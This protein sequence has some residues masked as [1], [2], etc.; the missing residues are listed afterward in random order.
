VSDAFDSRFPPAVTDLSLVPNGFPG[1]ALTELGSK[2]ARL[3]V[4]YDG[5]RAAWT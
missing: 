5:E 3:V 1:V 2:R 4:A